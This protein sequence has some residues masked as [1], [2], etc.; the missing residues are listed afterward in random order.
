MP[1]LNLLRHAAVFS[2]VTVLLTTA[3]CQRRQTPPPPA[4][5]VVASQ[6][7]APTPAAPAGAD[8]QD[9]P[10]AP[11]A[12][13]RTGQVR[14]WVKT[15]AVRVLQPDEVIARLAKSQSAS[16]AGLPLKR[17]AVCAYE[18]AGTR[19]DVLLVEAASPDDAFSLFTLRTGGRVETSKP[20]GSIRARLGTPELPQLCAWQGT[21][22]AEIAPARPAD[23]ASAK[24]LEQFLDRILLP[25][26][27]APPPFLLQAVPTG[28]RANCEIW[29]ARTTALL[30]PV[31]DRRLPGFSSAEWDRLFGLNGQPILTLLSVKSP[32]MP[33]ADLIWLVTY[34]DAA[35]AGAAY[36]RLQS[37]GQPPAPGRATQALPPVDRRLLGSWT[38]DAKVIQDQ[39]NALHAA[40]S[41]PRPTASSMPA[42]LPATNRGD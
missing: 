31:T 13:P 3:A 15:E 30:K 19:A 18:R 29:Q 36:E 38:T 24:A 42:P 1:F 10:A 37:P 7:E 41:G 26:P 4:E 9:D 11:R 12:L 5:P 34:P 35:L 25:L 21:W 2:A 16:P 23:A 33:S 6:P 32:E 22:F 17:G 39:L 27:A 28:Q 14:G 20:D 40:L 8:A